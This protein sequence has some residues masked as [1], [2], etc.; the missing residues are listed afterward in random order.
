MLNYTSKSINKRVVRLF[1]YR[2]SSL[3]GKRI[4]TTNEGHLFDDKMN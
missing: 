4:K 1:T 2:E 3:G